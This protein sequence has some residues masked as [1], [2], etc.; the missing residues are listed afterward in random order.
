MTILIALALGI[1]LL[2]AP[3]SQLWAAQY[4]SPLGEYV[5]DYCGTYEAVGAT[6]PEKWLECRK[7]W[8]R[9]KAVERQQLTI[10]RQRSLEQAYR[11]AQERQQQEAQ[12]RWQLELEE[13]RVRALEEAAQAQ[14]DAADAANR[15]RTCK[16]VGYELGRPIIECYYPRNPATRYDQ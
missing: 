1:A 2:V 5:T 8:E 15:T 14:R 10:E 13:R 12:R 9:L 16:T 7:E 6:N 11:Q 4:V 3:S